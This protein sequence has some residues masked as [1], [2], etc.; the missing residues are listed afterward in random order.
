MADD[1]TAVLEGAFNFRAVGG[2]AAAGG[3]RVARGRLYRSDGLSRLTAGDPEVL[4]GLGINAVIDLRTAD[5]VATRGRITWPGRELAYHH[6]PMLDVL[7]KAR[8]TRPIRATWCAVTPPQLRS[9]YSVPADGGSG[10]YVEQT[11]GVES[12][13]APVLAGI[14]ADANSRAGTDLGFLN[15]SIYFQ[16]GRPSR[17]LP[18]QH[19][20]RHLHRPRGVLRR[21][22]HLRHPARG[23]RHRPG[24]R[25]HD[26]PGLAGHHLR[27][28]AGGR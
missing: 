28:Q 14:V 18:D 27:D 26:R 16:L 6:L 23:P 24:L 12:A 2:L 15:P 20:D 19:A 25:Q 13:H 3:R 10:W 9:A 21:H 1:P 22:R 17:G 4:G 11:P 7:P 5:E 8:A